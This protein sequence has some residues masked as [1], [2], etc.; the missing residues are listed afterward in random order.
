MTYISLAQFTWCIVTIIKSLVTL[1]FACYF[2]VSLVRG[3]A[4]SYAP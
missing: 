3:G 2:H 1:G 4:R